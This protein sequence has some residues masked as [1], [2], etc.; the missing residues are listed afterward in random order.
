MKNF[1]LV[2]VKYLGSTN[3]K[4]SMVKLTSKRFNQSVTIP[5]DYSLNHQTQMAE[6]WLKENGHLV[7]GCGEYGNVDI[8]IC[9]AIDG[10]FKPLK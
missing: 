3:F 1:H 8:I 4:P 7:I 5:F 2:E 10:T 6:K 9:D